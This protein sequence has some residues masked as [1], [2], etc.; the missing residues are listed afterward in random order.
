MF[1][2][3]TQSDISPFVL[4]ADD[5]FS[6]RFITFVLSHLALAAEHTFSCLFLLKAD[7]NVF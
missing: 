6:L 2:A 1:T 4:A 7:E 3:V 5:T